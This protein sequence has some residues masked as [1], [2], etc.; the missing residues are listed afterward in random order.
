MFLVSGV[1][2]LCV[3][4]MCPRPNLGRKFHIKMCPKLSAFQNASK[5]A[6][7][8]RETE[9]ERKQVNKSIKSNL[10]HKLTY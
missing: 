5:V 7:I 8:S 2:G 1:T 4:Y 10:C 9:S 6:D 3:C